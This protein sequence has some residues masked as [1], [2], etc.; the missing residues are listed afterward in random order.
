MDSS[1]PVRDLGGAPSREAS[2]A[3]QRDGER[4]SRREGRRRRRFSRLT[5]TILALNMFPVATLFGGL[6][7]VGSYERSLLAAEHASLKTQTQLMAAGL[8]EIAVPPGFPEEQKLDLA[9]A[10][11]LMQRMIRPSG[12]VRARLFDRRGKM[13]VDSRA[14]L[15]PGGDIRVEELPPP[16]GRSWFTGAVVRVYDWFFYLLSR[17]REEAPAYRERATERADDFVEVQSA[18][19]GDPLSVVRRAR[20]GYLVLSHAEPVRRFKTVFGALM[21]ITSSL[22][23]D[24]AVR[25][26]RFDILRIFAVVFVFTVLVSLYMA[27]TIARPINRLAAAA[28]NMRHGLSRQI[29]IPDFSRRRDEIG[30]LS[31]TLR[32]LTKELWERMDAI[33]RFAAD[34]SHELKNPLSSLRSAIETAG[35]VQDP[36]ARQKLLEVIQ[37]DVGRLDRLITDISRASRLDAELSRVAPAPVD[38]GQA[39]HA[40]IDVHKA[41]APDA[42]PA[43]RLTVADAP[44]L[45]TMAVEDR[46]VQVF[47]NLLANAISFSPPRGVIE[48]EARL[49]PGAKD[50]VEVSISDQ[51]PGIPDA[52]L[53]QIFERFYSE[54][55]SGEK[56]G[57]HSGLGLSISRQIV[58]ASGGQIWAEN[59]RDKTGAVSGARLV[60]RLPRAA[61]P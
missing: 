8:G 50:M 61:K 28:D 39:L 60:V 29:T 1:D 57:T 25:R 45:W 43:V 40:L 13:V 41:T 58:E 48:I 59:R 11:L 18:L 47:H 23:V 7:Y 12:G 55:P 9:A 52:S 5:L 6:M 14:L 34:V 42:D 36:K 54:R 46:L 21:I 27:R 32:S 33:E 53:A 16:S 22:E 35:K 38:V 15:A 51:G 49:A 56:F 19:R 37:E 2:A 10:K 26:V 24:K 20:R 3:A 4:E 30:D 31:A 44:Q 17:R